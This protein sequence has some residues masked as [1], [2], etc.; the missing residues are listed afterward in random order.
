MLQPPSPIV[1]DVFK[2]PPIT[3]EI[4]MGDV[5]LG[6]VGLTGVIMLSALVVGLLVGGAF[7]WVKKMRAAAEPPAGAGHVVLGP[8]S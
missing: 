8:E 4:G 5:V 6:A 3:P 7:V 2:Q 1:V